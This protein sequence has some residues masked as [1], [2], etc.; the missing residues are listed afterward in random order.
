MQYEKSLRRIPDMKILRFGSSVLIVLILIICSTD[1]LASPRSLPEKVQPQ[2]VFTQW[3]GPAL[4]IWT[5]QPS[6]L[7]ATSPVVIV[8]H[9]VGR[10]A[11]RYHQE[12]ATYAERHQFLLVVPQFSPDDFPNANGYNLGNVF[13][14]GNQV[15]NAKSQWAFSAIEPL[16]DEV[17]NRFELETDKYSIYGHSAG[18]QFVHRFLYFVPE[19][20]VNKAIAA[21]AGWYTL[22]SFEQAF[23]YGLKETSIKQQQVFNVFSQKLTIL[24]GTKD[25][26]PQDKNLRRAAEAMQQGPHR[27]ARGKYFFHQ[28]QSLS[29]QH[30][31]AFNWQ[32]EFAPDVAHE[33]AKM[34][35]FAIP[36]LFSEK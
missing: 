18:A 20:R 26:D 3:Q 5:Y 1:S 6:N 15:M 17:K 35:P 12:W 13:K 25:N 19:A 9:G 10:D 34:I 16:F 22:A 28:M 24:L 27:L 14:P 7:S 11:D 21:N 29:L 4:N 33:N 36:L 8:M 30:Q 32:L 2:F 31:R 23:P